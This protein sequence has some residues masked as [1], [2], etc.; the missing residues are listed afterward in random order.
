M[1]GGDVSPSNSKRRNFMK[2]VC[3]VM[4]I[5]MLFLV[6]CAP[7]TVE[8]IQQPTTSITERSLSDQD[9]MGRRGITEE[10]LAQAE[11]ERLLREQQQGKDG[12]FAKDIYFEYDSYTIKQSELPKID[13]VGNYLKQNRGINIVAEGHCDERGTI[14]YNFALGQKRAEAAKAYLV[15][16]GIDGGRIK[17]ISFGKEVPVDTGHSED[18][19]ARNRRVHF[20]ID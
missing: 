1:R 12:S 16:M 8:T 13:A 15:K 5:G 6:G 4:V 11:R 3:V 20:K 19:W 10:E 17:T 2:Y 7:K 14:D 18:S 9:S